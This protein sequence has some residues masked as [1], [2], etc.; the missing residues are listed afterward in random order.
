M[1]ILKGK[2]VHF[3]DHYLIVELDD[4][5]IIQTPLD[6]YPELKRATI[7]QMR[8]YR[9]I[10]RG[11]GIEW[12]ALDYQLNIESMFYYSDMKKNRQVA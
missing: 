5:R 7:E 3:N 1:N 12:E 2:K 4:G 9:F 11:T 8:N 10:C 6:W